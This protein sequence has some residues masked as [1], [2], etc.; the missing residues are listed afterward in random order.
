M[1]GRSMAPV[2][3]TL[4]L[5]VLLTVALA[6]A[7]RVTR[8][9]DGSSACKP[10][11]Y[12][13]PG[14]EAPCA[15]CD[16]SCWTCFDG[17]DL[18]TSCPLGAAVDRAWLRPDTGEC[19]ATCPREGFVPVE[20]TAGSGRAC[21]A[22]PEG[23]TSCSVPEDAPPCGLDPAGVLTCPK[24]TC[25]QCADGLLLL[26][27]SSCVTSCPA[28]RYY[29]DHEARFSPVPACLRCAPMCDACSGLGSEKC[30][31]GLQAVI[32]AS[33]VV[34]MSILLAVMGTFFVGS[35]VAMIIMRHLNQQRRKR[36]APPA[37]EAPS[38]GKVDSDRSRR[39]APRKG[40]SD[41][42]IPMDMLLPR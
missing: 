39:M 9:S 24:V 7:L 2:H 13:P 40:P 5:A 33:V 14:G 19:M 38:S 4:I 27:G 35:V 28:T 37:A 20:H 6:G 34:I 21:L 1:I 25:H 32:N 17:A 8:A 26:D 41:E 15:T 42:A 11:E 22:C 23:C 12:V 29:T 16:T 31:A 10:G 36:K 18:C 30:T 3:R